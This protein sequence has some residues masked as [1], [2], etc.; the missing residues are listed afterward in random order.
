[1]SFRTTPEPPRPRLT[2]R[3]GA[4]VGTPGYIAPEQFEGKEATPATD[5]Y[6]LGI[7]L[8]ECVTGQR[9]F[10]AEPRGKDAILKAKNPARVSAIQPGVPRRFDEVGI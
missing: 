5:I 4:I 2:A 10:L 1:M 8:F 7:V 3:D 6:A 9:P